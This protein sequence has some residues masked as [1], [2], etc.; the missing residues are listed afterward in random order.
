MFISPVCACYLG[1]ERELFI[2]VDNEMELFIDGVPNTINKD[3]SAKDWT[4]TKRVKLPAGSRVIAVKATNRGLQAGLL[5]SVTDDALLSDKSWKVSTVEANEWA[6]PDT[7]DSK[8]EP[9]T[10]LGQ[11]GMEPW[12]TRSIISRNAKWIW[13]KDT[14][15]TV[16]YFRYRISEYL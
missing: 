9:A 6:S 15:A 3:P 16:V 14:R 10:E 13:S 7:D 11:H 12:K 5:A 8:W 4:V 1:A 2:T